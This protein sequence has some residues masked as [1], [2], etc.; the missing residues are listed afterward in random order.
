LIFI[1][2]LILA[3]IYDI[4]LDILDFTIL[5]DEYPLIY[6]VIF[7][8]GPIMGLFP[9]IFP[10]LFISWVGDK[11]GYWIEIFR[12]KRYED[13]S[14]Q[15][16]QSAKDTSSKPSR[17]GYKPPSYL[18]KLTTWNLT[19]KL[20]K[21]KKLLEIYAL[22][23]IFISI[24]VNLGSSYEYSEGVHAT[25]YHANGEILNVEVSGDQN[26]LDFRQFTQNMQANA[27]KYGFDNINA[28]YHTQMNEARYDDREVEWDIQIDSVEASSLMYYCFSWVNYSIL[29][30]NSSFR[31]E[32]IIGGNPEE[33]LAR[34][35]TPGSI[36]IPQYLLD[37]GVEI[38]E[39]LSFS[40][41]TSNGTII[42][43]EGI[44]TGAYAKFPASY[45]EREYDEGIDFEI[46]MSLDLIQDARIELIEIVYY[47]EGELSDVQKTGLSQYIYDNLATDFSL[48][49]MENQQYY[50]PYDS[51]IFDLF[52]IEGYLLVAFAFFG[53]II[54]SL[55]DSFHT[56]VEIA[57]LRAKGLLEKDL[58]K[59]AIYETLILVGLGSCH[60]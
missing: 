36:L 4:T 44:V 10:A 60:L 26:I 43:K 16:L 55:I 22:A 28:F 32:W 30:H 45:M 35:Q 6:W 33:I 12:R 5:M 18:K 37:K 3:Y 51:K 34:M 38:N 58:L 39:T 9:F 59:S 23:I 8:L 27:S 54:Y 48:R 13:I 50:D 47:T 31:D 49:F 53:F 29:Y 41:R 17:N 15:K 7:L 42:Q 57:L 24:S 11:L 46:Y 25:L 1:V 52:Q 56:N 19:H 21:N 20:N 40:Y 14:S 2:S